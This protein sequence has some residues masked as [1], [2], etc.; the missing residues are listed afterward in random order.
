M[1]VFLL[2]TF[3]TP[4][5]GILVIGVSVGLSLLG[6]LVVH[7]TIEVRQRA[8]HNE[9]AG[10]I[11]AALGVIYA[12]ILAFVVLVVLEQTGAAKAVAD[13]E[14]NLMSNLYHDA[15][16]YPESVR[17]GIRNELI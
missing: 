6:L 5:L 16:V 10:F 12:V 13:E 8:R 3:S 14:A 7:R 17:L 2:T 11:Y 15:D 4:V 9:V 1:D